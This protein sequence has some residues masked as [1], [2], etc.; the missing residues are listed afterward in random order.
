MLPWTSVLICK[1]CVQAEEDL[2][3][4][5]VLLGACPWTQELPELPDPGQLR[6]DLE[7][8]L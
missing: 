5:E 7:D 2:H 6:E 8:P 1:T 4:R 3:L